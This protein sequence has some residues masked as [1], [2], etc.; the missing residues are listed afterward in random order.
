M[1]I[2]EHHEA[3]EYLKNT[4][5]S[6]RNPQYRE[7]L[8]SANYNQLDIDEAKLIRDIYFSLKDI[9]LRNIILMRLFHVD[10]FDLKQ[11]FN[12]AYKK[13]RYLD[14]KLRAIRGYANYATEQEV[15]KLMSN[16][17]KILKKRPENTPYN[18]QEYEFIR[19]A[20]GLP[21]CA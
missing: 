9:S 15:N 14:M 1:A 2:S 5:S 16:F 12:D 18:Y 20:C 4:P 11:F 19:S 13:E 21:G 7:A 8:L 17:V 10:N 3:I 6:E